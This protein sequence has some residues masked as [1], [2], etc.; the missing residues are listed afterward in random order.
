MPRM[1]GGR[2]KWDLKEWKAEV[3][4]VFCAS[5]HGGSGYAPGSYMDGEA[6]VCGAC[7]LRIEDPTPTGWDVDGKP[8]CGDS[9][10]GQGPRARQ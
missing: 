2:T 9:V 7:G 3:E 4:V 5:T 1:A 10:S 8:V 6:V